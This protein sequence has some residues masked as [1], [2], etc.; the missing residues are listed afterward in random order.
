MLLDAIQSYLDTI[1][2]HLDT[3]ALMSMA[4]YKIFN[5]SIVFFNVLFRLSY[6]FEL[7]A[8]VFQAN[9]SKIMY[10]S[11]F[12]ILSF[13]AVFV[14]CLLSKSMLKQTKHDKKNDLPHLCLL[15]VF[16]QV[17]MCIQ[18]VFTQGP[19]DFIE[20]LLFLTLWR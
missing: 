12:C 16:G 18:A 20:N 14:L 7:V 17:H 9:I 6:L 10:F 4:T 19:N 3:L 5:V 1:R 13:N 15:Y 2:C 11:C 8:L